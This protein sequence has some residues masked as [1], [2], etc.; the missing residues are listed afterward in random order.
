LGDRFADLKR[1]DLDEDEKKTLAAQF[2]LRRVT[3]VRV[4]LPALSIAWEPPTVPGV[5]LGT[6]RLETRCQPFRL[7]LRSLGASP[8]I[9]CLSPVGCVFRDEQTRLQ[10]Q[11]KLVELAARSSIRVGVAPGRQEDSFDLAVVDDVLLAEDAAT[12]AQRVAMLI[13]RVVHGADLF[14][15]QFLPDNDAALDKF[16]QDLDREIRDDA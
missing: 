3:T 6:A 16:R 12:D 11:Q 5:L 13:R 14:E 1:L 8:L 7:Q 10:K 2:F 4:A 9:C 15:Q